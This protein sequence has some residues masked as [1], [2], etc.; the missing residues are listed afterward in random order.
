MENIV[1]IPRKSVELVIGAGNRTFYTQTHKSFF[2]GLIKTGRVRLI[3]GDDIRELSDG[4]CYMIPPDTETSMYP[5]T[6]YH[7]LTVCLKS[8]FGGLLEVVDCAN[9]AYEVSM[10]FCRLCDAFL[11]T[12]DENLFVNGI[13]SLFWPE[14]LFVKPEDKKNKTEFISD[15]IR[16]IENHLSDDVM[17]KDIA[18]AICVSQFHMCRSFKIQM[19]VPPKQYILQEKIR[20]V[21]KRLLS[22]ETSV[23]LSSEFG[24]SSQSH[25]CS[26]FRR[27]MSISVSDY[28]KN[29]L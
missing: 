29:V 6:P 28:L 18:K 3:V 22:G 15:A 26:V 1:F 2:I 5:I 8:P 20:M 16:Y 7:Y 21:K 17:V 27:L 13:L 23:A 25:M 19:R 9:L 24:F 4:M 10:E 11:H 12:G 14:R